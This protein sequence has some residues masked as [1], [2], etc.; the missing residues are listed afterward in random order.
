MVNSELDICGV[1]DWEYCYAAPVV[2]T[3]CP[4]SWLLLTH[5]DDWTDGD[6]GVLLERYLPRYRLFIKALQEE[7][8]EMIQRGTLSEGQRISIYMEKALENGHFWFC[9]A[10]T[11]S[12]GFDDIIWRFIDPLHFGEFTTIRDRVSLLSLQEQ[13]ELESLCRAEDVTDRRL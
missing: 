5:P 11:S 3:Y 12:F 9:L 10:A 2:F 4:P 7:E 1:I 6:L 8:T 13:D